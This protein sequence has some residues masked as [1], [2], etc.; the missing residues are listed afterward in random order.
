MNQCICGPF[1]SCN[2]TSDT[3]GASGFIE[4]DSDGLRRE[5]N[6]TG[7]SATVFKHYLGTVGPYHTE[8]QF[9]GRFNSVFNAQLQFGFD[10]EEDGGATGSGSVTLWFGES[11]QAD[12]A[13]NVG[14]GRNFTSEKI[15]AL[16][17]FKSEKG[18]LS[19]SFTDLDD[20]FW[21]G[22]VEIDIGG[23]WVLGNCAYPSEDSPDWCEEPDH[24]KTKKKY[25]KHK[26]K[27]G[28]GGGGFGP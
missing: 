15:V 25:K 4:R 28:K 6:E 2:V 7:I 13:L 22:E 12:L 16:S 8:M 19:F 26:K 27:K 3:H 11:L 1:R 17:D 14:S 9:Q 10:W 18:P 20:N 5:W 23:N 21:T 24:K